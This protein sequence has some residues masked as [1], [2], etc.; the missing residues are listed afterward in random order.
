M[1]DF[2]T[3]TCPSCGGRLE[4]TKNIERFTCPYCGQEHMVRRSGRIVSLSPTVDAIKQVGIGVDNTAAELA[5]V[6][7]KTEI[8]ELQRQKLALLKAHP[9]PVRNV[10]WLIVIPIVFLIV[11]CSIA[12]SQSNTTVLIIFFSGIAMI[13]FV[14]WR[15]SVVHHRETI[16]W[17]ETV[18]TQLKSFDTQMAVKNAE[19]KHYQEIVS[20]Q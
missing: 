5:I 19:L 14:V 10:N 17:E 20:L 4:I 9:R 16:D 12:T 8:P 2:I 7:L 18:G 1:D 6:R 11:M 3:L 13:I 15:L